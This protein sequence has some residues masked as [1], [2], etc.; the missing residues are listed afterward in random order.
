MNKNST[1]WLE[2]AGLIKKDVVKDG[3]NNNSETKKL[4][5]TK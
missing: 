2:K 4:S 3:T 5:S 1:G